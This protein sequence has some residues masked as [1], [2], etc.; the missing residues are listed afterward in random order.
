MRHLLE[1]W[2]GWVLHG[3]YWGII[4]LMAMESSIFPVPSEVVIPPAA[5]L[6][7]QGKLSFSGVVLAGTLGSY[8]GAAITYWVSRVIGR[9]LIVRYGRF[10][11]INAKK[12]EQAENWLARYEGGGVFFARLLPVVRHL[13]SIPAGIV[14]MNFW[15]FSIVTIVGSGIWCWILAYLGVQAYRAEPDLLSNPEAMV[16]FIKAQS[17]WILLFVAG[18]AGLYILVVR[19]MQRPTDG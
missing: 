9:P 8:L 1:I 17:H 13:I 6:A 18:F 11:L 10:V 14:R 15:I 3:G 5:F 12:L 7:A 4:V 19:L 16:H 2:V